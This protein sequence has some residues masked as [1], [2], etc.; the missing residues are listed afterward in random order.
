MNKKAQIGAQLGT[1][2]SIFIVVVV[3]LALLIPIAGN[4]SA[5]TTKRTVSNETI[6]MPVNGSTEDLFGQAVSG[7]SIWNSTD[8]LLTQDLN[9]SLARDV[10]SDAKLTAQ[11]TNVVIG[12]TYDYAGETMT[13]QYSYEPFG[14]SSNGG[15]RSIAALIILLTALGIGIIG[16]IMV[17]KS[18]VLG[19]FGR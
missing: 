5:I 12:T 7:F 14:Y 2:I 4:T 9:Y 19:I 15:T 1:M 3:G 17:K 16:I 6:T 10:I 8:V 11:I 13:V 18:D